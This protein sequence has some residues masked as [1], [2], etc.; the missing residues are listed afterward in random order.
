MDDRREIGKQLQDLEQQLRELQIRY[1]KYFSG[2]EKLEPL[3]QREDVFRLLRHFA[4]RRIVQTDLRFKYQNLATRYHAYAAQWD[5]IQRMMDEGKYVRHLSRAAQRGTSKAGKPPEKKDDEIDS[6]YED[7]VQAHRS[8]QAEKRLPKRDQVADFL[9]K[10]KA[11][12]REKYGDRQMQFQV[13]TE[14]GKPKI[15]VK[16]RK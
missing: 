13:V 10:Q 15:K 12:L 2:A 1:E 16:A 9:Q 14:N 5:R 6:L 3:K 7:L 8:T 4:N 11:K